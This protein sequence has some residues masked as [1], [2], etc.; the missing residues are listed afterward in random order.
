ML[1]DLTLRGRPRGGGR[2]GDSGGVLTGCQRDSKRDLSDAD[3]PKPICP[4]FP[5]KRPAHGAGARTVAGGTRHNLNERAIS[6][7]SLGILA[8]LSVS[9][10][11]H[12]KQLF[13]LPE[14]QNAII[15]QWSQHP[16][17]IEGMGEMMGY[18]ERRG[19]GVVW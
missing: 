7:E 6:G 5:T 4:K 8:S 10:V 2:P 11:A 15:S 16:R 9:L 3:T 17:L 13:M 1:G 18:A 19:R 14:G 12:S